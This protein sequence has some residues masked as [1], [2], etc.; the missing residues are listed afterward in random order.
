MTTR[1]ALCFLGSVLALSA[2][3]T[4]QTKLEI[5]SKLG[6]K[7]YSL[8]D[9]KGAI[10][11]ADKKLAADPKSPALLLKRRKRNSQ[12]GKTKRRSRR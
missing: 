2:A 5:T 9:E 11:E 12:S 8:P 6:A 3:A 1:H 10:A 4:V 7:F